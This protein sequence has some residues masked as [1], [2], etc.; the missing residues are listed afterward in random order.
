MAKTTN[1]GADWDTTLL[2]H[3]IA[4]KFDFHDFDYGILP[5]MDLYLTKDGWS[6]FDK[7][8]YIPEYEAKVSFA[9]FASDK[10]IYAAWRT[11]VKSIDSGK[12]WI[13]IKPPS[14]GN[15]LLRPISVV[16][17][18]V[19][20]CLSSD[21]TLFRTTDA[22]IS[23]STFPKPSFMG[24][25]VTN[26]IFV[27]DFYGWIAGS[28]ERIGKTTDGGETWINQSI[29]PDH[30]L[31]HFVSID[32]LN[33][34]T[35]VLASARGNIYW[36]SDG[37]DNWLKRLDEEEVLRLSTIDIVDENT[38]YAGG[39]SGLLIKTTSGGITDI[40]SKPIYP[41][42]HKLNGNY[43][44]PFNPSTKIRYEIAKGSNV[45]LT[46]FD[47]LGNKIKTLVDDFRN[48]GKY[49]IEFN[50]QELSTGVYIYQLKVNDFTE[51]KKM[52]LVK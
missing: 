8:Y 23:W 45:K 3:I 18:S 37:G 35:A 17:D 51:S 2:Y 10:V 14:Q 36:T 49:E 42:T 5:Y 9:Q 44:N 26:L 24:A 7:V 1:G 31:D 20:Y 11:V 29:K 15:R 41:A 34:S 32:A 21:A 33:E 27:S 48:I 47:I 38:A 40:I 22:G 28:D 12:T 19:V 13:D 30:K 46:V 43:P 25:F 16:N 50:A 6:T 52:I 4:S 39:D